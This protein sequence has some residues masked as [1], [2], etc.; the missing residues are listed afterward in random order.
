MPI[1][2]KGDKYYQCRYKVS[3]LKLLI[4]DVVIDVQPFQVR[5]ISIENNFETDIFPLFKLTLVL[6]PKV[7]FN[8]LKNKNEIKFKIRIQKYYKDLSTGVNTMDVDYIHDTFVV[9]LDDDESQFNEELY[10]TRREAEGYTGDTVNLFEM[11][12]PVD[13]FLF[14]EIYVNNLRK[15]VNKIFSNCTITTVIAWLFYNAGMS[16]LLISALDN[17]SIIPTVVIPPMH[18]FNALRFLDVQY[19]FYGQGSLIYF[20]VYRAYILN[21]RIGCTAWEEHEWKNSTIYVLD[22]SNKD[23]RT[24]CW[25]K[26]NDDNNHYTIVQDEHVRAMNTS[27]VDNVI[28]GSSPNVIDA[29]NSDNYKFTSSELVTRG[30]SNYNTFNNDTSN[31][32]IGSTYAT[33]K[34]GVGVVITVGMND[35]NIDAILP[36]KDFRFIFEESKANEKYKG[37]YKI[38]S[39]FVQFIKDGDDYSISASCVF[40][41]L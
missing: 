19:G 32:F 7:Y 15:T 8:I 20:D 3:E 17:R 9:F 36:N 2:E 33:Q 26:R 13:F 38:S 1:I 41:R 4:N 10:K 18:V 28:N 35:F 39:S 22:R 29:A 12:T 11:D 37:Q 30:N 6:N 34:A 27:I 16:G 31:S 14:R 21:Y 25:I 5:N 23:N 24:A 40:K